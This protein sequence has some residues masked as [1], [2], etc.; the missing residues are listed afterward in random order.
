MAIKV[1]GLTEAVE[2]LLEEYGDG[3]R[4]AVAAAVKDSAKVCRDELERTSPERSGDYAKGW[5]HRYARD[6]KSVVGAQV[7]NKD[8]YQLTH[9]LERGHHSPRNGGARAFPHIQRAADN[10]ARR[11]EKNVILEV[12]KT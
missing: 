1:E 6:G 7:Y 9:L 5:A 10:A 12:G 4:R 2:E 11:L 8:R 3:V